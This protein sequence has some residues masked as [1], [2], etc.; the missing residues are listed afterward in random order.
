[1]NGRRFAV[2]I[3]HDSALVRGITMAVA[4]FNPGIKA[5][6]PAE[7]QQAALH[8]NFYPQQ[9]DRLMLRLA[10]VHGAISPAIPWLTALLE[11]SARRAATG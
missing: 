10:R 11:R 5:F 8:A 1:V 7:F 3:V 4:W 2:A 6:S 9:M